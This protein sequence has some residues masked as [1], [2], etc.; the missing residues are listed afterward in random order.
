M[1][2]LPYES[3]SFSA[4]TTHKRCAEP[5]LTGRP[6]KERDGSDQKCDLCGATRIYELELSHCFL[7]AFRPAF[8]GEADGLTYT[9]SK[10]TMVSTQ[11]PPLVAACKERI[12]RLTGDVY[13]VCLCNFYRSGD[14]GV[15]FHSD[16]EGAVCAVMCVCCVCD[17]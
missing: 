17:V 1:H 16:A 9:Y 5:R 3:L 8:L 2:G 12:E 13:N 11:W 14:E 7:F 4:V 15:G 6:L 10:K